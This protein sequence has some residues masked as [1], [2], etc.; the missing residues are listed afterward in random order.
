M[1]ERNV[2]D[3]EQ[4]RTGALMAHEGMGPGHVAADRDS[5]DRQLIPG[6]EITGEAEKQRQYQ[7]DDTH[8]PVKFAWRFVT[9]GQKD[10]IHVQPD[11]DDHGMGAPA[12][13]LAQD[14]ESCYVT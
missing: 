11:R 4:T 2:A 9:A 14:A 5:P 7:Q 3:P 8:P 10:T 6:E 1:D 12:V 13:H